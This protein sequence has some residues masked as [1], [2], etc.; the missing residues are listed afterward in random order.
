MLATLAAV[1]APAAAS[2][3]SLVAIEARAG[4][5]VEV[6]GAAGAMVVRPSAVTIGGRVA[7]AINEEPN[8]WAWV[9]GQT[10]TG[11]RGSS[12]LLAGM[13]L[14][15]GGHLH[16]DGG[17]LW[18]VRPYS[19]FG[20]VATAGVCTKSKASIHYCGDVEATFL[21]GGTDLPGGREVTQVQ[22]VLGVRFDAM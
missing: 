3:D 16:L 7:Y 15:P 10:E 18:V 6:G 22:L 5:G 17:A 14:L 8:A 20:A 4:L 12:G 21:F 9:G 19:L 2:P 1:G 13:R 11:G